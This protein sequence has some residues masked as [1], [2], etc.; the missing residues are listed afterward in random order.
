[1]EAGTIGQ[2]CIDE[3][4]R[5]VDAASTGP[6]HELDQVVDMVLAEHGGGELRAT[7][8]G[9]E[10]LARLVDP[11]FLH[12]RVVEERLQRPHA[13]DPVGHRLGHLAGV[14]EG[15]HAHHQP[16]LGVVGD[17]LV[18]ELAY[19]DRVTVAR[20]EPASPDQLSHLV[21]HDLVGGLLPSRRHDLDPAAVVAPARRR[22]RRGWTVWTGKRSVASLA[23]ACWAGQPGR[24]SRSACP[25]SRAA[26]TPGR[27]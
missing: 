23:R 19:G 21:L 11:D 4:G 8:L 27:S 20:V 13:D 7:G 9:H 14:G 15:R 12:V 18:D 2:G 16:A 22:A 24:A 1:M 6:K 25:A 17:H 3:R 10:H 5:E 26:S